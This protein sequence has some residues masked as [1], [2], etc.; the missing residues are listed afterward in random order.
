M[1]ETVKTDLCIIGAGS[2]GLSAAA[3][4]AQMGADVVLLEGGKMGGDCLNYG[5][6]PSKALIAAAKHARAMTSGAEFGVTPV[7][8]DVDFARAKEHVLSV[9]AK[10]APHDSVERFEGLGVRV[11]Q[12]Y[13]AFVSPGEVVAGDH[14]IK[15][16]RF[17]I[18][19]GSSPFVP[20]IPGLETTPFETNETIFEMRDRPEHLVVIGGGPIGLEMAQAHR[21]LGCRVTVLEGL[22]ALSRSHPEHAAVVLAQLRQ[23]GIVIHEG[24]SVERIE[25][26]G[27]TVTARASGGLTV[28][29]TNLLVAVGRKPNIDRLNLAA[30]GIEAGRAGI[31]VDSSLKTANR[32]VYAIG[33]AAGGPQFTHAAGY[34]ASV[35]LKSALFGLPS[36]VRA[37][38]MP[39]ATYTDPEIAEAGL[40]EQDALKKFGGKAEIISF[41]YAENDRALAEGLTQGQ[42][43]AT[44]VRGRPVGASIVGSQAGEMIHI[45]SMAIANRL[46]MNAFASMIAPYPTIGEVSKRAAGAYFS[47]RLFGSGV[48]KT[49]VRMVQRF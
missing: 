49:V 11:V 36:K 41:D 4:A 48:V 34:H 6:V 14:R 42:V 32:R 15:A 46:K 9:I 8:P 3:G 44:V 45:W 5:C 23:E 39:S 24:A 40:S 31:K 19:T 43:R 2:G 47:K 27:G 18:A 10:I 33:D 28:D 12:E 26:G 7:E 35:V 29:G 25:G 22:K 21:R 30:A 38:H 1:P 13:G 37:D 16:R 17:I 20:P